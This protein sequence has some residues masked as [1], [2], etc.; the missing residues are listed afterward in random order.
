M[1]VEKKTKNKQGH[2]F[3]SSQKMIV[4][5]FVISLTLHSMSSYS[6]DCVSDSIMKNVNQ[7]TEKF[8]ESQG[9]LQYICN[10]HDIND[11]DC[12]KMQDYD[13]KHCFGDDSNYPIDVSASSIENKAESNFDNQEHVD[14]DGITATKYT[15]QRPEPMPV[16]HFPRSSFP[17]FPAFHVTLADGITHQLRMLDGETL[18]N[19]LKRFCESLELD[20]T[21]CI[22]VKSGYRHNMQAFEMAIFTKHPRRTASQIP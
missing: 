4:F 12:D 8:H 15:T 16:D 6:V 9:D 21:G 2:N 3:L 13:I 11:A 22:R 14:H 17:P 1:R 7:E 5:L 10:K 18:S 19:A 20:S